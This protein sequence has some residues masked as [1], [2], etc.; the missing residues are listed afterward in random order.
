MAYGF[1]GCRISLERI[2]AV[3]PERVKYNPGNFPG[4]EWRATVLDP[5][6]KEEK[7]V[8]NLIFETGMWLIIGAQDI[9]IANEV[10]WR[11]L[12]VA[13]EFKADQ[14]SRRDNERQQARLHRL[15]TRLY[16]PLIRT[17]DPEEVAKILP[18]GIA[19]TEAQMQKEID[20][21][22]RADMEARKATAAAKKARRR[23]KQARMVTEEEELAEEARKRKRLD[24]QIERER[25]EGWS[26][27]MIAAHRGNLGNVQMLLDMGKDAAFVNNV[28]Q[29][30]LDVIKDK[31]GDIYKDIYQLIM[32]HLV[33]E[34][35]YPEAYGLDVI[36]AA[37]EKDK[38][39]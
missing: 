28:G 23:R 24:D 33:P 10:Y 37:Q 18:Y 9:S 11:L 30:I 2:F 16:E 13:Q 15:W 8:K 32:R 38:K 26:P 6:T 17:G 31:E 7:T 22:I 5:T 25:V 21:K 12:K 29:S 14:F 35:R 27:L 3:Y 36:A 34:E 1:L 20:D 19:K 4:L 39:R